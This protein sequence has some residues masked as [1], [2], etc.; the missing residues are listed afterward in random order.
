MPIL[1]QIVSPRL[2]ATGFGVM[3]FVSIGCGGLVVW[4]FGI[5]RARNVSEVLIFDVM[6]G[7]TALSIG[8]VLLIRPKGHP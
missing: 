1:A 8:L 3:N 7:V 4:A 2:R 5:L 6:G